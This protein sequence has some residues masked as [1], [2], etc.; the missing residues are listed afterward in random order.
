ML[1]ARGHGLSGYP[2]RSLGRHW[3]QTNGGYCSSVKSK[4]LLVDAVDPSLALCLIQIEPPSRQGLRI[5]DGVV[6][7]VPVI[8]V[9][10]IMSID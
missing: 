7:L 10:G 1:F 5:G 3:R 8:V 9:F 6:V 2:V 4:T